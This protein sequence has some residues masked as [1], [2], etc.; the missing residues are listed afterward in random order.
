M[1]KLFTLTAILLC[2]IMLFAQ[3]IN[4]QNLTY[5]EALE[6]AKTENKLVFIDCYTTWCG[7]CQTMAKN[8]FP[9]EKV[10]DYFNPRF[11]SVKYDMEKG[12][13]VELAK[14]FGLQAYPT[15]LIIN[16]DGT[17]RHRLVGEY[18]A[19]E[20][21]ELVKEAF[22]DTKALGTL[23]SQ[24]NAGNRDKDFLVKY[25]KALI[26]ASSAEAYNVALELF[27]VLTDEEKTSEKYWFIF[28][29][30]GI[31]LRGQELVDYLVSHHKDF[32]ASLGSKKVDDYLFAYYSNKLSIITLGNDPQATNETMEQLKKNIKSLHLATEKALL[33]KANI[34]EA[35]LSGDQEELLNVCEREIKKMPGEE[36]PYMI[37]HK[38]KKTATPEQTNRWAKVFRT[39]Q[40]NFIDPKNMNMVIIKGMAMYLE[41]PELN[42]K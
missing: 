1:K 36:F 30:E 14:Q 39:V 32:V 35:A 23:V 6:K 40:D 29:N 42:A 19:D 9:Q 25:T 38:I 2:N 31:N 37:F 21:I 12:E 8:I 24:F 11:I 28:S 22:D 10:G 5:K 15:F 7:P 16:P 41:N 33:A 3:G 26:D 17:L 20:F 27:K 13:G 4:F 34:A 18:Q